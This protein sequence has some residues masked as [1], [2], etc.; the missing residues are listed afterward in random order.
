MK[1]GILIAVSLSLVVGLWL[2]I[3]NTK[4]SALS[5]AEPREVTEELKISDTVFRGTLTS[6]KDS[7]DYDKLYEQWMGVKPE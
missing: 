4:V 2:G 6:M 7:G 1:K 5:C 3:D